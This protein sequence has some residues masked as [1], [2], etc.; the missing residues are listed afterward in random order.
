MSTSWGAWVARLVECL[1]FDFSSGHDLMVHECK[2]LMGLCA[3]SV[4]PAWDSLFLSLSAPPLLARVCEWEKGR[5]RGRERIPSRLHAVSTEPNW[6]LS[7]KNCET[8][9]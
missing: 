2:P 1:T 5:K 7:H 9:T 4:E 6:G 3:D 8:M